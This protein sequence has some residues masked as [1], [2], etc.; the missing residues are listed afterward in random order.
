M[1]SPKWGPHL[2]PG[3]E[4]PFSPLTFGGLFFLFYPCWESPT[5]VWA[6]W[7]GR[8]TFLPTTCRGRGSAGYMRPSAPRLSGTSVRQ[9]RWTTISS[10]WCRKGSP[11]PNGSGKSACRSASCGAPGFIL[12][13][14]KGPRE[15]VVVPGLFRIYFRGADLKKKLE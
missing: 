9:G 15:F 11:S 5:G 12:T 2:H 10:D 8:T 13:M 6:C 4:R 1:A 7:G 3:H 14:A